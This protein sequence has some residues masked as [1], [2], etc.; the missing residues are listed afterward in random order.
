M[1][2]DTSGA[3]ALAFGGRARRCIKNVSESHLV[4]GPDSAWKFA[5]HGGFSLNVPH[6]CAHFC[7]L[8]AHSICMNRF[9]H[10][11]QTTES[12]LSCTHTHKRVT[13]PLDDTF[14]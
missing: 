12:A 14:T 8:K 3:D 2:I 10:V 5:E 11:E 6:S 9:T 1:C 13:Q 7:R 4:M